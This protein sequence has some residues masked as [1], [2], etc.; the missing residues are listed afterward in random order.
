MTE[1]ATAKDVLPDCTLQRTQRTVTRIT[2]CG[3]PA[4][5]IFCGNCHVP[6]G[7]VAESASFAF[8][9]C[10]DCEGKWAPLAGTYTTSD[11]QFWE[12]VKQE[13]LAQHGRELTAAEVIE[14]LKDDGST[15]SKLIKDR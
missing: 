5:R 11:E 8:W 3:A 15:I 2:I 1:L 6:G 10:R 14:E 13:Q 9:L 12:T 7:F 4:K